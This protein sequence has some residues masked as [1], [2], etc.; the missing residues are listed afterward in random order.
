MAKNSKLSEHLKK[1]LA[2]NYV[3]YLKTQNFHWNVTGGNFLSLHTLFEQQ[4]TDLAA[5]ID[6]MAERIRALGERAPGSFK[7]F[8]SLSTLKEAG[9]EE[10]RAVDM[11]KALYEDQLQL[12]KRLKK[13]IAVATEEGDE[14]TADFLTGRLA[15]HEKNAWMLSS[16]L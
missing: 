5:A 4:Y 13:A 2:D 15:A 9:D 3:L 6:E 8:L 12:A 10:M 16:S 11:V 14:A 1:L 7:A